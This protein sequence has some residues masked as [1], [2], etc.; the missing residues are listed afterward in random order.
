MSGRGAGAATA[1][2]CSS[3]G[4]GDYEQGQQHGCSRLGPA[5]TMASR[6]AAAAGEAAGCNIP[7]VFRVLWVILQQCLPGQLM[8]WCQGS[9][10]MAQ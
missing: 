6:L 4:P 5:W 1:A 10:L 9:E 8:A 3:P 7:G 2:E